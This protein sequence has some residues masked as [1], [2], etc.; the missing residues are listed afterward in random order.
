MKKRTIAV[1]T[2]TLGIIG[3]TAMAPA[4]FA[5]ENNS[6]ELQDSF[7]QHTSERQEGSEKDSVKQRKHQRHM[8]L[9]KDHTEELDGILSSGD[10]EA[11]QAQI[12]DNAPEKMKE[13]IAERGDE[14]PERMQRHFDRMS[15]RYQNEGFPWQ[16]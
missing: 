14:N 4:V 9:F 16:K 12:E 15:E 7:R 11:F 13:K 8:Q 1:G 6:P 10:F 5:A 3:M 2:L